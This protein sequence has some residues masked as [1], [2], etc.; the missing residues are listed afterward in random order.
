MNLQQQIDYWREGSKEDIEAADALIANRKFR[1]ALFFAHL[2]TEKILKA[3]LAKV[4]GDVPPR[5][6]DLLRLA[7]LAGLII[8]DSQRIF[9]ARLQRYCMEGRYP[10]FSPEAPSEDDAKNELRET[11]AVCLWLANQL[12]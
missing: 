11:R 7:D 6:H 2:A 10:D 5:T 3:H 4:T 12:K 8:S 9:L 1:Q